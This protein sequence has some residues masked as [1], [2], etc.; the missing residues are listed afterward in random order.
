[1]LEE[2]SNYLIK[3]NEKDQAI[4]LLTTL[5][6]HAW[7]FEEYDDLARVLFKIKRYSDS[8]RNAENALICAYT[9]EKMW[10]ARCNLINVYN[11]ANYPELAMKYIKQ[12]E[13]SIPDDLDNLLEKA[14]SYF[15]LNE[16][17]K[18]EE[19]LLR[20]LDHSNITETMRT[21]L[22]FNLGTYCL[23]RDEFQKGMRLFLLEGKKLDYWQKAKLPFKFWEGGIF[24]GKTLILFAEA[25]IGD[26]IINIR[27]MKIIEQFGMIPIWLTDRKD[28]KEI[29]NY[30]GFRTISSIK[31][32]DK[33]LD[34]QDILWTYPM[35]LPV[36]LNLQYKDL[37]KG[38]YLRSLPDYDKKFSRMKES[39]KLKIGLRWQGNPEYDQDLHRSIPLE[40]LYN[41]IASDDIEFYSLQKDN[42]L[43]ELNN[44]EHKIKDLSKEMEK[45][46]DTLSIIN[47]CDIIITSCTSIAHAAAALGKRTFIFVPISAYYIYCNTF[48][49]K[50]PWYSDNVTI[51]R[52]VKNKCWKEPIQE[53]SKYQL[54]K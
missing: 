31:E 5:E 20:C 16:K 43:E 41:K 32:L 21:K 46:G 4:S 23:Y 30:N 25:G 26:E 14:F 42:G 54:K 36:Y 29:F 50:T 11:H 2:L 22:L 27:F 52:Q 8:I 15:L 33:E 44:F 38:S 7:T 34:P 37:W 9:N 13:H 3:H 28:L 12:C 18:A 40:D 47:N 48:K 53:L 49:D 24:P 19:I 1:M 6:K 17:D 10:A 35:S 45:F 39:K 51:L